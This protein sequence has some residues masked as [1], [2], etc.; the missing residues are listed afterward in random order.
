[1]YVV[2][3]ASGLKWV[4]DGNTEPSTGEALTNEKLS[5]ALLRQADFTQEE[6]DAFGIKNLLR[7][8]FIKS[9]DTY[10]KPVDADAVTLKVERW[11]EEAVDKL[12]DRNRC[13]CRRPLAD[14]MEEAKSRNRALAE[15]KQPMLVIEETIAAILYTGPV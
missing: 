3:A 5:A 9:G 6:W 10:F 11:P 8:H 14:T 4:A 7:I 1:L 12:P 2:D 13:R 15:A